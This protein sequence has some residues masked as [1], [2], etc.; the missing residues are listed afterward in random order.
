MA[1][2]FLSLTS[3]VTISASSRSGAGLYIQFYDLG[4][5][6][7]AANPNP[8]DGNRKFKAPRTGAAGI[9]EQDSVSIRDRR[10]V[11]MAQGRSP[12]DKGG[13]APL[14]FDLDKKRSAF[15]KIS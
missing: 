10:T 14:I 13:L 6:R 3:V 1:R 2:I 7:F 5:H 4:T 12:V 15:L 9:Q 11:G 8:G